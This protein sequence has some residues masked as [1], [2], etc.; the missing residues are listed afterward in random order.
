MA[1]LFEDLAYRH[2]KS[3]SW[4]AMIRTKFRLRAPEELNQKMCEAFA[5]DKDVP[6]A[7]YRINRNLLLNKFSNTGL[8]IPMTMD[9]IVYLANYLFLNLPSIN[10]ITPRILQDKFLEHIPK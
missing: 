2:Y 7:L 6:K 4:N 9:N 10:K 1:K 3:Q 8:S 5:H